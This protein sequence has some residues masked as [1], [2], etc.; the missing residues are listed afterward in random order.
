VVA[1]DAPH[2]IER[3]WRK[4][5]ISLYRWIFHG[6][7]T[8][9]D[10]PSHMSVMPCTEADAVACTASAVV[11]VCG[12]GVMSVL[13]GAAPGAR[14]F[15][16]LSDADADDAE[17]AGQSELILPSHGGWSL[18]VPAADAMRCDDDLLALQGVGKA[19]K[20]ILTRLRTSRSADGVADDV[21]ELVGIAEETAALC[22]ALSIFFG[23]FKSALATLASA[24]IASTSASSAKPHP[25]H[26][27]RRRR[28]PDRTPRRYY[29]SEPD[30]ADDYDDGDLYFD[31]DDI[32]QA[33]SDDEV[34]NRYDGDGDGRVRGALHAALTSEFKVFVHG[35]DKVYQYG[36]RKPRAP[37][38]LSEA[39]DAVEKHCTFL[40]CETFCFHLREAVL[41]NFLNTTAE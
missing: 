24:S 19:A 30:S 7:V 41:L 6:P 13:S 12:G 8:R 15:L 26:F 3:C 35:E 38:E 25:L 40:G 33:S 22:E 34:G 2:S 29:E 39:L 14:S 11:L 4:A 31:D 36:E 21:E 5:P 27:K 10:G 32:D 1:F 23:A 37:P 28:K 18:S 20:E 9:S 16:S 17:N